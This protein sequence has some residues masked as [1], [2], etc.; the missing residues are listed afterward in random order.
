MTAR[1][2]CFLIGS[3]DS[4]LWADLG[5]GPMAMPD[6]RDRWERIWQ[7]RAEIVE[8]AH[9]HPLGPEGF[10]S[11][12]RTTMAAIDAALG[13]RLRYSVVSPQSVVRNDQ[14]VGHAGREP[15]WARVLRAA[16]GIL[17]NMEGGDD[18]KAQHHVSGH[19]GRSPGGR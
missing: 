14:E 16:S 9:S 3:D 7:H 8:I 18:G 4:I 15:W 19:V 5:A 13:R 6:S 2:V 1:E 12:D 10:S 17:T 11:E